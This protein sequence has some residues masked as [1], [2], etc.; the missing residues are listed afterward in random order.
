M[1]IHHL[2]GHIC[3]DIYLLRTPPYYG[4]WVRKNEH[5][6]FFFFPLASLRNIKSLT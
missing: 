3:F 1:Y 4:F 2:S 6:E 5:P